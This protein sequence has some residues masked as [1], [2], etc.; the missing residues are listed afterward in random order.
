LTAPLAPEVSPPGSGKVTEL[1]EF[2]VAEAAFQ[3]PVAAGAASF[4]AQAENETCTVGVDAVNGPA[5]S[6]MVAVPPGGTIGGPTV[7]GAANAACGA[8]SRAAANPPT[9]AAVLIV[10]MRG[11][12]TVMNRMAWEAKEGGRWAA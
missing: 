3:G 5:G 6:E 4:G 10:D 8:T 7:V 2:R 9:I 12:P 11:P 1:T